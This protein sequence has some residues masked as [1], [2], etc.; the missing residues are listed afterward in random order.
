MQLRTAGIGE[1]AL[2]TKL[3]P[4]F[5]RHGDAL[6][7]AFCAHQGQVDCRLSSPSG[8]LALPELEAIAADCAAL[9]GED[10]MCYGH[11]SMAQVCADLLRSMEKT[12]A[13]GGIA[14][15]RVYANMGHVDI[16]VE[17]SVFHRRNS[18]VIRD[19][20]EFIFEPHRAN[21]QPEVD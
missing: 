9:L 16:I 21:S 7:I 11:S 8:Q 1:S 20:A 5:D 17:F 13:V 14:N 4:L 12:L 10:F 2:E 6:S 18:L 3:Q 19:I 15:R